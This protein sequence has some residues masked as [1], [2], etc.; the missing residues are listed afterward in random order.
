MGDPEAGGL[1]T[2]KSIARSRFCPAN[3]LKR[4]LPRGRGSLRRVCEPHEE[5]SYGK[6]VITSKPQRSFWEA[7]F[8]LLAL[9]YESRGLRSPTGP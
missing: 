6:P 1:L 3:G 9:C 7:A 2:R 4:Q 8:R 5:P